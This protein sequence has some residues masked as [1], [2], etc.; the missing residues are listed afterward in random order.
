L[1]AASG[2]KS[3][4]S[5]DDWP[6]AGSDQLVDHP[7][8]VVTVPGGCTFCL[9]AK[10]GF[11][12]DTSEAEVRRLT[13]F[14][15]SCLT[16]L[17]PCRCIEDVYPAAE[18]WHLY[19]GTCDGRPAA[20]RTDYSESKHPLACQVPIFARGREVSQIASVTS[21]EESQERCSGAVI[22][23]AKV[24]VDGV[25]KGSTPLRSGDLIDV[26]SPE[27]GGYEPLEKEN[28]LTPGKHFLL[29]AMEPEDAV[30]HFSLDRCFVLRD[31]PD[32]RAQLQKGMAANDSLRYPDMNT[33]FIPD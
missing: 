14:N 13:T 28:P 4:L 27:S 29:L 3:R 25:L 19:D 32:I 18:G 33:D 8:Y 16:R 17:F 31:T 22:E 23:S 12:L 24:R 11:A 1:I 21:L 9:M 2:A 5:F 7:Q 6:I 15:L 26:T 30:P 20:K 10:V